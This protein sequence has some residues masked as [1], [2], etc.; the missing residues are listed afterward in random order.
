M[1]GNS[2]SA[3]DRKFLRF[4]EAV[5]EYF[6]FLEAQWGYSCVRQEDTFVR[7]EKGDLYVDIYHGRVSF[8]I[9]V[10]VGR[11]SLGESFALE[12]IV[13]LSDQGLAR[14]YWPGGARTVQAVRKVV[15]AA[16]EGLRLYGAAALAGDQSTFSRLEQLSEERVAAMVRDSIAVQVRPKA[17]AAFRRR[18]YKEAATL[19]FSIEDSLSPVERKKLEIAKKRA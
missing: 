4:P 17:E 12:A 18:D 7:Y 2:S 5:R 1:F 15:Q 10:E 13:S 3:V 19:Y 14:K 9:G 16:S 11:K 6:S 8:E